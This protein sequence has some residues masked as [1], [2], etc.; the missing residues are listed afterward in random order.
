MKKVDY[1]LLFGIIMISIFGV[2]MIYSASYVW[3]EYKFHDPLKFAKTQF[4]FLV[5]SYILI[6]FSLKIPY[7]KYLSYANLIFFICFI[8]LILVLIPGIGTVRNGSRSWFGI[9]GFGIQPS[10]FTKLGMIIFTSKYLAYNEK[11]LK[12]I[13]SGVLPILG[14]LML[15]FGLIMLQP[16]FGTGVIIVISIIVLLFVSGV[17]MGFFIKLGFIGLLGV[18]ALIIAAPYR[19][20]RIVS[21]LN[22]W[23]DPLGSG[24]Q[25]I[26]SLYAIGP[27]GLLGLGFGNSI[28]KHFYLPEP[29]T[30]FIF[31]IISEEF[32]FLGILI[33]ASLF[34]LIIYRGFHI[35]IHCENK[36]GKY[37]SFGIT[38]QLAFQALLNLMVVVGLIP[39]TGVTLPFLSYGGSSLLITMISMGILLNISKYNY[40]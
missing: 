11:V 40:E 16:D 24:F 15:V 17:N 27:G 14:V 21:F 7:Q 9:G 4:L 1:L 10:E 39:V 19:M 8:L 36:F 13:K 22:P 33:V 37:L 30:D 25:I 6:F 2:V 26:Q 28:Q 18:V 38:F 35:S 3:A 20:K 23:S 32:G 31:A 34:L 5:V 29:Q 12:N